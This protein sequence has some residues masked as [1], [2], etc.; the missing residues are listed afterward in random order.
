[1]YRILNVLANPDLTCFGTD[2]VY[3]GRNERRRF[4]VILMEKPGLWRDYLCH[5]Q[6][7]EFTRILDIF[8]TEQAI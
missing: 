2:R 5:P 3:V 4:G 8:F 6:R 7:V 1:M